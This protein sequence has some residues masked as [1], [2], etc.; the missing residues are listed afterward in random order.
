MM[1]LSIFAL[2]GED[3]AVP[4]DLRFGLREL[5]ENLVALERR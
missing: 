3:L 4:T 2:V 1:I 5:G